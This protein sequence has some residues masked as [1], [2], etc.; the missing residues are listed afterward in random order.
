MIEQATKAA[1]TVEVGL[2][3]QAWWY[4][5]CTCG[6]FGSAYHHKAAAAKAANEHTHYDVVVRGRA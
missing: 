6:R 3:S 2:Q 1:H 5:R 4:W